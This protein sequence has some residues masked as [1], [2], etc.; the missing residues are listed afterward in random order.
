MGIFLQMQTQYQQQTN[1][2]FFD[3]EAHKYFCTFECINKVIYWLLQH[4]RSSAAWKEKVY[5]CWSHWVLWLGKQM[6]KTWFCSQ[7]QSS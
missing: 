1:F 4:N 5:Y 7:L 6:T 2:H 3:S